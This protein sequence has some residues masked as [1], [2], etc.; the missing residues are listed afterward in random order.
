MTGLIQVLGVVFGI[1]LISVGIMESLFIRHQR[2]QRL[3]ITEADDIHRHR[4]GTLNLGF[5]NV[6]WG[7]G[8]LAGALMLGGVDS[9]AGQAVLLFVCVGHM[10][11][12]LVLFLSDR[13]LWRNAVAEAFLPLTITVLL[14]V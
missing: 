9:A 12:G 8:A 11:L 7:I 3:F 1:L 13:R 14:L 5:Y 4:L 6:V 2:R 10:V